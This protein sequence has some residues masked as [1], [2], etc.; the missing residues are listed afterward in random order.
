M[1][2]QPVNIP[3]IP[4]NRQE[5]PQITP[6]QVRKRASLLTPPSTMDPA[7]IPLPSSSASEDE[8]S[9]EK[10][11]KW[12]SFSDYE[13]EEDEEEEK[14][15]RRLYKFSQHLQKRLRDDKEY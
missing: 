3:K 6:R 4:A 15:Q 14:E 2:Q 9:A 13:D 8:Q 1:L 11:K 5:V 10:K 12:H 7:N